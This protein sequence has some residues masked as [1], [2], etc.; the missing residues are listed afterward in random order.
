VHGTREMR[1][2]ELVLLADVDENGTVAVLL[3]VVD[4]LR[5]HLLDL[6]LD[7]ADQLRA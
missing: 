1:L 6:L 7:L 2:L 5:V 3:E 4:L